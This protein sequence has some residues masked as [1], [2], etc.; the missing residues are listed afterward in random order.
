MDELYE[1]GVIEEEAIISNVDIVTGNPEVFNDDLTL[2]DVII[3]SDL[4]SESNTTARPED[5]SLAPEEEHSS[6]MA[7]YLNNTAEEGTTATE[8]ADVLETVSANE[9]LPT[10]QPTTKLQEEIKS[11][12]NPDDD[13]NTTETITSTIRPETTTTQKLNVRIVEKGEDVKETKE[14]AKKI[15]LLNFKKNTA[16]SV[17]KKKAEDKLINKEV[18][19]VIQNNPTNITSSVPKKGPKPMLKDNK[20]TTRASQ[21][22]T[23]SSVKQNETSTEE[24]KSINRKNNEPPRELIEDNATSKPAITKE[25]ATVVKSTSEKVLVLDRKA[26]W[27]M[28]REGSKTTEE[29]K[30]GG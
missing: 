29:N 3:L 7:S 14:N 26:L 10:K 17:G 8:Q 11:T 30:K 27:G 23:P 4:D 21:E 6:V 13:I 19:L 16:K 9:S 22:L 5:Q 28:L 25:A 1:C 18:I 15:K 24:P 2:T 12:S 20:V